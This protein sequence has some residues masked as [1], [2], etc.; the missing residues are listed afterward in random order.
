[1]TDCDG[2]NRSPRQR[3]ARTRARSTIAPLLAALA[4][5]ALPGCGREEPDPFFH[6][7]LGDEPGALMPVGR[8]AVD[9]ALLQGGQAR[10][11]DPASYTPPTPPAPQAPPATEP[12]A[13]QP[14]AYE[15]E[16]GTPEEAV[17]NAFAALRDAV[18]AGEFARIP[19]MLVPDQQGVAQRY[20][21]A[22]A[23]WSAAVASLTGALETASPEHAAALRQAAAEPTPLRRYSALTVRTIE[24]TAEHEAAVYVL[25]TDL[26]WRARFIDGQWRLQDPLLADADAAQN[27]VDA[28]NRATGSI[29]S[30]LP[31]WQSGTLTPEALVEQVRQIVQQLEQ[32]TADQ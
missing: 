19:T 23:E 31:Q 8:L 12:A 21:T 9:P 26:P 5:L 30:L 25:D 13:T 2:H 3:V 20:W 14:V 1:M 18:R 32:P 6:R 7:N 29:A 10:V 16:P 28:L 4:V 11:L 27:R 17:F 15:P 22:W 24:L